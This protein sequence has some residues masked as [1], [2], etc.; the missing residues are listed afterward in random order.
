MNIKKYEEKKIKWTSNTSVA[1]CFQYLLVSK[2]RLELTALDWMSILK[3][4]RK[5]ISYT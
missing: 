3:N 5:L 1:I 2:L 4:H